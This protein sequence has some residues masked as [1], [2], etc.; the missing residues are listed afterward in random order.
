MNKIVYDGPGSLAHS[1]WQSNLA[2]AIPWERAGMRL[3]ETWPNVIRVS[4]IT[5]ADEQPI[6]G[7]FE[8]EYSNG[9]IESVE[10]KST[11]TISKRRNIVC[12]VWDNVE[13]G[14]PGWFTKNTTFKHMIFFDTINLG[15][16]LLLNP[17][18][19]K[20]A[21]DSLQ[22]KLLTGTHPTIPNRHA[23]FYAYGTRDLILSGCADIIDKETVL[24]ALEQEGLYAD[25][26]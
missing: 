8:V 1:R 3:A 21:G 10:V 13:Y 9:I 18:A 24:K 16:A 7:D 17:Y 19:L 22:R 11:S 25:T 6:R 15:Y 26:N 20:A 23:Q 12:P 5:D 4:E 2:K 14:L